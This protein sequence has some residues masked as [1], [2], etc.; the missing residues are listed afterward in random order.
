MNNQW[1]RS[2]IQVRIPKLFIIETKPFYNEVYTRGYQLDGTTDTLNR[3]QGLMYNQASAHGRFT[4]LNDLDI[5]NSVPEII[6]INALPT[7]VK[8]A[9]GWRE[10]RARFLMEVESLLGNCILRTYIQGYTDYL[11]SSIYGKLDPNMRMTINSVIIVSSTLDPINGN[12]F[13]NRQAFYN[14]IPGE[15]GQIGY[16]EELSRDMTTKKLIRPEDIMSS[17]L[18]ADRHEGLGVNVVNMADEVTNGCKVSNRVNNSM[19]KYFNR[20]TSSFIDARNMADNVDDRQ[21]IFKKARSA[22]YEPDIL[23]NPFIMALYDVTGDITSSSFTLG[24][25]QVLD[26]NIRPT[27]FPRESE[28]MMDYTN[29]NPN[30]GFITTE[31]SADTLQA[32]AENI[33]ATIIANELPAYMC[34]CLITNVSISMTNM[35]NE[36]VAVVT[37]IQTFVS[38][39]D[40]TI[41]IEPLLV[42]V[43]TLLMTKISDGGMTQFEAHVVADVMGEI[44]ISISLY[45]NP[46]IVYR[47]PCYADSLYTPV[48]TNAANKT[49]LIN[50]FQNVLEMTYV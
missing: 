32:T 35:N 49:N 13:I 25:L 19:I 42:R 47:F 9:N 39:L 11:D 50:D 15:M 27:F 40:P 23:R 17:L 6:N 1:G 21:E 5:A 20:V 18:L 41:W 46:H 10:K 48:V 26:P 44:T 2:K 30:L 33:K 24:T 29:G 34:E 16:I 31:D 3:L 14:I 7:R 8:I 12:E 43:R 28:P 45:G 38:G 4:N 36:N 37:G 22:A